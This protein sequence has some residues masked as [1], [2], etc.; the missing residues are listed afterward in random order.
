IQALDYWNRDDKGNAIR[1]KQ[2]NYNEFKTKNGR[3]VFDGG[4]VQPDIDIA[5]AR[6]STITKAIVANDY[7]FDYA[8]QYYYNNN[9]ADSKQ[10]KLTDSDFNDFKSFLRAKKFD[11]ETK[12]EKALADA[13]KV[14]KEEQLDKELSQ[15]Y[16]ALV[17]TLNSYKNKA[18]D[19]NKSQLKAL[20][21]NEIIKRYFYREGLHE[22][23][24]A[25]NEEVKRAT[26]ILSNPSKYQ[27]Y[28]RP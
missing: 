26:E 9:V 14:A 8:T 25:N 18:I 10:F 23:Y 22:Y 2:E 7:I 15:S 12:T 13:L 4:G 16:Q 5:D 27:S 1:V 21:E 20:L 24:L 19:E 11:F 3:S 28:L 6:L 17:T